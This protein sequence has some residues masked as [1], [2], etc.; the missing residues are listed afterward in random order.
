MWNSRNF[1]MWKD[2]DDND[3]E[4]EKEFDCQRRRNEVWNDDY[5]DND[6]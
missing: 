2:E 1:A 3:N 6:N 5:N 4:D